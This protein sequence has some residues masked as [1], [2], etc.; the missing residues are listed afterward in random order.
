[1]YKL[2]RLGLFLL[3]LFTFSLCRFH[4]LGWT[5]ILSILLICT[6][7]LSC[8][9]R[10]CFW[11]QNDVLKLMIIFKLWKRP[12]SLQPHSFNF[13]QSFVPNA[14]PWRHHRSDMH[15]KESRNKKESL[16][17]LSWSCILK[18]KYVYNP[19]SSIQ[20]GHSSPQQH[21]V[22]VDFSFK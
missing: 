9:L 12:Q 17:V 16:Y 18:D 4:F 1:M 10:A 13:Y 3:F 20:W 22:Q 11:K 21:T 19:L 6:S 8:R 2:G 7:F 5:F 15:V 14:V